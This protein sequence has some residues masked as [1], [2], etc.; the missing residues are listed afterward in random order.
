MFEVKNDQA[1]WRKIYAKALTLN[2]DDV[3][4]YDD[5]GDLL[6]RDFLADRSPIYRTIRELEKNNARTLANVKGIGYRLA[7]A[8]EHEGLARSH[9]Q[10][11]RRQL[12]KA[13]S[14]A[15]S[16]NR[17]EMTVDERKRIDGLEMSLR[18]HSQMIRRLDLRDKER[19]AQLKDLRREKNADVAELSERVDRL[20][21]LLERHGVQPQ[22]A[23]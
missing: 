8:V 12:R 17:A 1:E 19:E 23:S 10:R 2:V 13:V 18:Q 20:A 4:T 11:S 5:L 14:K 16:A 9:H 22:G 15:A 7:A 3:L 21:E 6:D